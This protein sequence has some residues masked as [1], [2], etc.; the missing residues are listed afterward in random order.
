MPKPLWDK[1]GCECAG[2]AGWLTLAHQRLRICLLGSLPL[3]FFMLWIS[4][5]IQI[6]VKMIMLLYKVCE[7]RESVCLSI[8]LFYDVSIKQRMPSYIWIS[9]TW[10][11]KSVKH[12]PNT[13]KIFLV[14]VK[15]N[16]NWVS[17]VFLH[18]NF[19][20]EIIIDSYAVVKNNSERPFCIFTC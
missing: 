13:E 2:L 8:F 5:I 14:Y 1:A 4:G 9:D 7:E 17:W 15:F 19:Y 10:W 16:F 20:F 6:H 11:K 18:I 12:V 3:E